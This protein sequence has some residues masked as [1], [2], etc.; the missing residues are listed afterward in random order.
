MNVLYQVNSN[1]A[2]LFGYFVQKLETGAGFE[3]DNFEEIDSNDFVPSGEK[4]IFYQQDKDNIYQNQIQTCINN[5]Q[6]N[7]WQIQ[8]GGTYVILQELGVD[9][10]VECKS[11]TD[12]VTVQVPSTEVYGDENC[13]EYGI[14]ESLVQSIENNFEVLDEDFVFTVSLLQ[15][16]ENIQLWVIFGLHGF[17]LSGLVLAAVWNFQIGS[18][19]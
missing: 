13:N 7:E 10:S 18:I 19:F 3:N 17:A 9:L 5:N 4:T 1:D 2:T 16:I 14:P 12:V 15:K 6:N 8:V 11:F